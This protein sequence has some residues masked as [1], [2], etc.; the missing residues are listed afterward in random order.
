[1]LNAILRN[2]H[3][4]LEFLPSE[5]F[6]TAGVFE[7]LIYLSDTTLTAVLE[8]VVSASGLSPQ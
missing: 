5:D 6:L 8:R 4:G 1:M 3:R 7:R 2:K